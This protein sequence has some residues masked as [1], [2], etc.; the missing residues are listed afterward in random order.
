MNV[1]RG[2]CLATYIPLQFRPQHSFD[3]DLWHLPRLLCL[4]CFS[5]SRGRTQDS[6][7]GSIRVTSV[8][9][10]FVCAQAHGLP[11][12]MEDWALWFGCVPR[13]NGRES[14]W[15]GQPLPLLAVNGRFVFYSLVLIMTDLQGRD[16]RWYH[17]LFYFWRIVL[18]G[19][20]FL[21]DEFFSCSSL[22][23]IPLYSGLTGVW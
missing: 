12:C 13:R 4:F 17:F 22:T 21:V 20:E 3:C 1:L 23:I 9:L 8:H 19:K 14:W 10:Q 18:P 7:M 6:H 11:I 2:H 5:Y 15:A 16:I